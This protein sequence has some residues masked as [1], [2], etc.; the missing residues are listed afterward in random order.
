MIF[1]HKLSD[2]VSNFLKGPKRG[3]KKQFLDLLSVNIKHHSRWEWVGC[4]G[5]WGRVGGGGLEMGG[6]WWWWVS[7]E[8]VGEST[9]C[10]LC[11]NIHLK[12]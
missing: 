2:I 10:L 12:V 7:G 9:M 1:H 5:G 11:K 8:G 3:F 4:R 6:G